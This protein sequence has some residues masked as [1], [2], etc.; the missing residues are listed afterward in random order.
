LYQ[1]IAISIILGLSIAFILASISEKPIIKG[2][3]FAKAVAAGDLAQTLDI[4][5]K[6]EIGVLQMH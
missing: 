6:D 3:S 2:V 1:T 5:Q 4:N